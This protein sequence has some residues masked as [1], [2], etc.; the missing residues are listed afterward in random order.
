V[1]ELLTPRKKLPKPVKRA[2]NQNGREIR[3]TEIE[4]CSKANIVGSK[5]L[6]CVRGEG[7][8]MG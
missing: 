2:Q 8:K 7:E 6:N 4:E 1:E 5:K 3:L